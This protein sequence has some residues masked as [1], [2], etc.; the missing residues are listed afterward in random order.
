MSVRDTKVIA[1]LFFLLTGPANAAKIAYVEP[2]GC[3]INNL[4]I[5][6]LSWTF[7]GSHLRELYRGTYNLNQ[8][9]GGWF[10]LPGQASTQHSGC[11]VFGTGNNE[12]L[13]V[14]GCFDDPPL[15]CINSNTTVALKKTCTNY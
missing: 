5:Y 2:V 15:M 9:S 14:E 8:G 11:R 1:I 7:T 10:Y 4:Q 12:W 6:L 3:G 13:R